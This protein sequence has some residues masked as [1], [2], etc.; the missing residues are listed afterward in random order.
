MSRNMDSIGDKIED[1][2]KQYEDNYDTAYKNIN[3]SIGLFEDMTMESGQSVES[4]IDSLKSQVSYMDTYQSN[5]RKAMELGVDKGLVQKLS[6]GSKESAQI[7]QSI[8]DDGGEHVDE[9]NENLAKVEEGKQ[10]FSDTYA[11]MVTDFDTKMG[12]LETRLGLAVDSM[13]QYK[14]AY[15]NGTDT[16]NGFIKG[17]ESKYDQVYNAYKKVAERANR[18][19]KDTL[20]IHSPSRVMMQL[21]EYTAEGF[22]DGVLME[23]DT[24]ENAFKKMAKVPENVIDMNYTPATRTTKT[25]TINAPV[26]VLQRLDEAELNRVGGTISTIVGRQF[27]RRT[28]GVL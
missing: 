17:A 16:V 9:L 6:D 3:S 5:I 15:D 1:L 2:N 20:D 28:G 8:V 14:E 7:L 11:N 12:Q 18:A 10:A 23:M 26:Q 21:G 19:V 27:A 13:D 24:V 25:V 4:M 22:A